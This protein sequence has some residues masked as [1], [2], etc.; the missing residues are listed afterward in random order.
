MMQKMIAIDYLKREE[1]RGDGTRKVAGKGEGQKTDGTSGDGPGRKKAEPVATLFSTDAFQFHHLLGDL[2]LRIGRGYPEVAPGRYPA[3]AGFDDKGLPFVRVRAPGGTV[4]QRTYSMSSLRG[5]E[6]LER[7][8]LVH[9][10]LYDRRKDLLYTARLPNAS[11]IAG[12]GRPDR[13]GEEQEQQQFALESADDVPADE[14]LV[15]V[16]EYPVLDQEM[17][18]ADLLCLGAAWQRDD[19]IPVV[20][21]ARVLQGLAQQEASRPG[22]FVESGWFL[23]G[24]VARNGPQGDLVVLI[25]EAIEAEHT[26][27]TAGSLV[28]TH[29]SKA[30][31]FDELA[32][33]NAGRDPDRAQRL[34]GWAHTHGPC[35]LPDEKEPAAKDGGQQGTRS[36]A[37]AGTPPAAAGEPS[38]SARADTPSK[39]EKKQNGSD[40]AQPPAPPGADTS[41]GSDGARSDYRFFSADDLRVHR[42]DYAPASIALVLDAAAA[43]K[44]PDD[45]GRSFSCYGANDGLIFR[46]ALYLDR[47]ERE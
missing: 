13:A 16:Q 29:R 17:A 37:A 45:H 34:V 4:L 26:Q 24:R 14:L 44:D 6:V 46:R 1:K 47:H 39:K 22:D 40:G 10:E 21:P 33:R 41:D 27:A 9:P 12:D 28:F 36:A 19:D 11:E 3:E 25:D 35:A 30:A 32:R 5:D 2:S 18:T 7:L 43:R 20:C 38:V 42:K 31:V 15:H 8:R 23:L